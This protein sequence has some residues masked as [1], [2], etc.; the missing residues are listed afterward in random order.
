[1]LDV[2]EN[3]VPPNP[4]FN[5]II[6]YYPVKG[7]GQTHPSIILGG[8][9]SR[10]I[11]W[12]PLIMILY[13]CGMFFFFSIQFMDFMPPLKVH[14]FTNISNQVHHGSLN[15]VHFISFHHDSM[16]DTG[17]TVA[18]R[19]PN[20]R[21]LAHGRGLPNCKCGIG[22]P[23]YTFVDIF[24]QQFSILWIMFFSHWAFPLPS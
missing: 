18:V 4:M 15:S 1:M 6:I 16:V 24:W 17:D 8:F 2:F 3:Q 22:G 13:V 10:F 23:V 14:E 7:W 21:Y 12:Y 5:H 11:P 20:W 19:A 9:T